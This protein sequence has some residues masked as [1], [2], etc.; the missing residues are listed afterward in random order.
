MEMITSG[1]EE[2]LVRELIYQG[3][4]NE[5]QRI[6]VKGIMTAFDKYY[7]SLFLVDRPD[8]LDYIQ[9][10]LECGIVFTKTNKKN[11]NETEGAVKENNIP[12]IIQNNVHDIDDLKKE[13]EELK[14]KVETLQTKLKDAQE[15]LDV[16]KN[17][18]NINWHDKVRLELAIRIMEKADINLETYGNKA[19]A[20]RILQAI[21]KLPISTCSNYASNRDLSEKQHGDEIEKINSNLRVL[22]KEIQL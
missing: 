14:A 3:K 1:Y 2:A 5:S 4:S 21:T 19:K 12:T 11:E 20:A 17:A 15:A 8:F 6:I 10:D 9:L 22:N 7:K 16:Y 13:N 18:K